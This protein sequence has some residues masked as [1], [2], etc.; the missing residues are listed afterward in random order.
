MAL[1]QKIFC[2]L[3]SFL[4]QRTIEV[5]WI[6]VTIIEAFLF[7]IVFVN[8]MIMY[9]LIWTWIIW[10]RMICS[11]DSK[12]ITQ[13]FYV[14]LYILRLLIIIW[15]RVVMFIVGLLTQARRCFIADS[16]H[17]V[18]RQTS[19]NVENWVSYRECLYRYTL[20]C[21]WYHITMSKCTGVE[22]NYYIML[23]ICQRIWYNV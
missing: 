8:C 17:Y 6:L 4:F 3:L 15:M 11:L 16:L 19:C 9:L 1:T 7:P 13:L 12:I 22:W 20:L 5:Q 23:W 14:L 2:F 10:R 21:W 18:Y